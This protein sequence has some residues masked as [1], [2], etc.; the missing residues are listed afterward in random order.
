M[1]LH[2]ISFNLWSCNKNISVRITKLSANFLFYDIIFMVES[3]NE[4]D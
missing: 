1:Y 4:A 2:K 3:Y